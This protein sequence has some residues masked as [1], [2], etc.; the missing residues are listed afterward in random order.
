MR[1]QKKKFNKICV[2]EDLADQ[3][4]I[5]NSNTLKGISIYLE[6]QFLQLGKEK[7]NLLINSLVERVKKR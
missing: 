3:W 6:E 1:I 7:E 2:V 5:E 4:S